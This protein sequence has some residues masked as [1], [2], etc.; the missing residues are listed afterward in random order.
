MNNMELRKAT[1]DD[2]KVLLDW[3]NDLETRQ[4]SHNTEVVNEESHK[5]WLKS[6]LE[7]TNRQLFVAMEQGVAVGTVR[8]DYDSYS[9]DYVLSWTISPGARG[10]GIGKQM[11]KLLVDK[12]DDKI[13]AEIRKGNIASV[14]I[15]EYAGLLFKNEENGVLHFSNY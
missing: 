13:R 9:K 3:R 7:N 6:T 8:A 1:F 12:L 11:V 15:A 10:K 4:S 5:K 14:K 2:W